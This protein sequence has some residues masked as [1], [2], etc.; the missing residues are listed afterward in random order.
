MKSK[1]LAV[2]KPLLANRGFNKEELEGLAEI[3]VKNLNEASTDE[4]IN[5]VVNGIVP[6]ADLMQKVSNRMVTSVE[7]KYKGWIDPNNVP[8]PEPPKNEPPKV[9]EPK[10]LSM[11]DIQKMIA[12][13]INEGLKP[14]REREEKQRLQT[15][16]Y[17]HEKVKAV[18]EE[19]R[20][21]YSLNKEEDLETVAARM[22]ND[23]TAIK[24]ALVKSGEFVAPP[25]QGNGASETDDLVNML[26]AMGEKGNK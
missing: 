3:A 19:F 22:E 25:Q 1:V 16:L 13:G 15:L 8:K 5:N 4:D 2:L 17:S 7:H 6:Y 11:E 10:V 23:Y 21:L 14:Y 20:N 12:D 18:P 26:H 9:E 24:Q